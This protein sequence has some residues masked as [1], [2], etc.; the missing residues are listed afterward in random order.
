MGSDLPWPVLVQ[1]NLCIF[2]H[3]FLFVLIVIVDGLPVGLGG[4]LCWAQSGLDGLDERI[5]GTT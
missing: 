4:S 3:C 2:R 5:L 1:G